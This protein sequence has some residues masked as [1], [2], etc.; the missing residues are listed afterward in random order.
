MRTFF[1]VEGGDNKFAKFTVTTL[2]AF[3]K[4][5][6]QNVSTTSNNLLLVL[7]DGKKR[8][9]FHELAIF[10]LADKRCKDTF[11]PILRHLYP[12]IFAIT[13]IM[14]FLLLRN[15]TFNFHCYTHCEATPPQK[16]AR[17]WHCDLSGLL[18]WKI[19]N[20]IHS[21][22]PASLNRPIECDCG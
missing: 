20:G 21:C 22:K 14:A 19:T 5:R 10:W 18:A 12:V 15:S 7:Q 16:S 1:T 13:T 9:F 8:I 4:V 11:F 6:T 3:L 17:K 2:K